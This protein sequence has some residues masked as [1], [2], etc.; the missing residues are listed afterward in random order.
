M[1]DDESGISAIPEG[2]LA[3]AQEGAGMFM[4]NNETEVPPSKKLEKR[5]PVYAEVCTIRVAAGTGEGSA[6]GLKCPECKT[7]QHNSA[8]SCQKCGVRLLY[9]AVKA[10]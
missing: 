6:E 9:P 4:F 10:V 3:L 1:I 7:K 5:E 8:T 2:I